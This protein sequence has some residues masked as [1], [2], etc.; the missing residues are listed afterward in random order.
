[1]NQPQPAFS[2]S[3]EQKFEALKMRYQDQVKLLR[4][5][6]TLDFRIFGGYITLQLLLGCWLSQHPPAVLSGRIGIA[7][8]DLALMVVATVF[9]TNN[10]KRRAEVG[11][12]LKNI[13]VALRFSEED[14][15]IT[16]G[17]LNATIGFRAWRYWSLFGIVAAFSGIMLLLF[18]G[19]FPI[20]TSTPLPTPSP[21]PA[22]P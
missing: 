11:A 15:Y 2:L 14:A 12:T 20:P 3:D 10:Y 5:M 19:S 21:T 6:T 9:L 18:S 13:T 4:Y 8:I 7:A 17:A 16:P 1:M 22:N